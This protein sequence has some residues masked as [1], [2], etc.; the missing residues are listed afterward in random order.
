MNQ[1]YLQSVLDYN[2]HTGV[3]TWKAPRRGVMVGARA[4]TIGKDE[5]R[6]IHLDGKN[7]PAARLAF[8]YMK[9]YF[10]PNDVDHKNRRRWDDRWNNLRE[11]TR[12]QNMMN[13]TLRID[14]KSGHRGVN[15]HKGAAKWRAFI[16]VNNITLHLGLYKNIDDAIA[17]RIAAEAKH[18]GEFGGSTA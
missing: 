9:G 17:A 14:N 7:Y 18:H 1:T 13:G 15:W 4:G 8:L 6:I 11:A 5:Y 16:R 10:P 12:S 3:F 2:E